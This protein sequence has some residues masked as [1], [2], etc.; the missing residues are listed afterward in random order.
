MDPHLTRSGQISNVFDV[1][2]TSWPQWPTFQELGHCDLLPLKYRSNFIFNALAS[3]M[4]PFLFNGG[5]LMQ[6]NAFAANRWP[7]FSL[8]NWWRWNLCDLYFPNF[9]IWHTHVHIKSNRW[10]TRS[11]GSIFTSLVSKWWHVRAVLNW[12]IWT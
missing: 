2:D 12:W 11:Y 5:T 8:F 7:L 6:F 3:K 10:D 4:A 1:L 9:E